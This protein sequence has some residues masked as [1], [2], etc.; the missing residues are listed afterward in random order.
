MIEEINEQILLELEDASYE[1]IPDLMVSRVEDVIADVQ[2]I[3]YVSTVDPLDES[4]VV[5]RGSSGVMEIV[6]PAVSGDITEEAVILKQNGGV[7]SQASQREITPFQ[8]RPDPGLLRFK[9]FPLVGIDESDVVKN[10]AKDKLAL[11][12]DHTVPDCYP[13]QVDS[14]AFFQVDVIL[15][16]LVGN[17]CDEWSGEKLTG[18][19]EIVSLE[20]RKHLEKLLHRFGYVGAN[21]IQGGIDIATTTK[22]VPRTGQYI[23]VKHIVIFVPGIFALY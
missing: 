9:L 15:M 16:D 6:L 1:K 4:G 3:P 20:I 10:V 21:V 5:V 14:S 23:D 17:Y 22:A 19:E 7:Q 12:S 11:W 13:L 2:G 18:H 8:Q